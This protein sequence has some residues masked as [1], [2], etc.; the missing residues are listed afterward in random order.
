LRPATSF[1]WI[2]TV[3]GRPFKASNSIKYK[4]LK[5]TI[6]LQYC[7]LEEFSLEERES[8]ATNDVLKISNFLMPCKNAWMFLCISLLIE[9]SKIGI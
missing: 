9:E 5:T 1:P 4:F 7:I 2:P 8:T 3:S 6:S